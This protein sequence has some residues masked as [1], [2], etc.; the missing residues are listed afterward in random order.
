[1]VG[2]YDGAFGPGT[3]SFLVFLFVRVLGFDFLRASASAKLINT[4][5]NAAALILFGATG[6]VW[7]AL[8]ATMAVANVV[9]S[10]IGTTVALRHG[11]PFVRKMFI[12]VVGALILKT[13]WDAF[14]ATG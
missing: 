6:H 7:W 13:A 11:A 12:A 4:A 3:G 10:L 9:G 5:T 1:V 2:F 14:A 8:A